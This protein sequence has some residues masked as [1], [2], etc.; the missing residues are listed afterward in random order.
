MLLN[1]KWCKKFTRHFLRAYFQYL[2]TK[3]VRGVKSLPDEGLAITHTSRGRSSVRGTRS[4]E[5]KS[6][7]KDFLSKQETKLRGG[8]G[9]NYT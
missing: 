4:D 9:Y 8:G 2:H 5:S 7:S 3:L 6:Q 1:R